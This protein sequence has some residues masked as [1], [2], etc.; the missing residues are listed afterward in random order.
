MMTAFEACQA[1]QAFRF[2]FTQK[3]YDFFKYHAKTKMSIRQFEER[4]D[5]YQ[6]EK[7]ASR[8][9]QD[10]YV[11]KMLVAYKKDA[12]FW[13][14]DI[15]SKENENATLKFQGYLQ[16]YSTAF[17]QED[18]SRIREML[19]KTSMTL[20]DIV[21]INEKIHPEFFK[22]YVRKEVTPETFIAVDKV[23]GLSHHMNTVRQDDPIWQ[24]RFHF[25]KKYY[26]FVAKY[27]PE[28]ADIGRT[29]R[30]IT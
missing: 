7:I 13:I 30:G 23:I 10:K 26:P 1:H 20:K 6:F 25:L 15:I 16:G 4:R 19:L 17:F 18:I 11:L 29:L 22:M 2:H 9:T 27:L 14:G 12:N 24:D 3:K 5:R 8:Y 21:V 28:K